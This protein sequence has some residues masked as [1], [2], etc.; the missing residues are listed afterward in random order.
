M[1]RL[2]IYRAS[3]EFYVLAQRT[4]F[5]DAAVEAP[6]ISITSRLVPEEISLQE[7]HAPHGPFPLFSLQLRAIAKMRAVVVLPTP[8]GPENIY[9]WATL[10]LAIAFLMVV[11]TCS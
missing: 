8:R 11:V 7:S 9:A 4:D 2:C 5:V 10:L 6:S 3:G 1:I